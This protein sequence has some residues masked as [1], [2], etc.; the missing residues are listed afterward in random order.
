[1]TGEEEPPPETIQT[2]M[3]P[4]CVS[5]PLVSK[6]TA[7]QQKRSSSSELQDFFLSEPSASSEETRQA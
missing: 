5:P 4:Q 6:T 7:W 1:M 3:A 2:Q